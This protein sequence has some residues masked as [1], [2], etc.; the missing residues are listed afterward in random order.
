MALKNPFRRSVKE[1]PAMDDKTVKNEASDQGAA[2]NETQEPATAD[3]PSAGDNSELEILKAELDLLRAEHQAIHD[4][5]V[6]LFAEFDNFRKRTA[7]ERLELL[8]YA[9]ENTLKAVLPV[10][11][12]MDRAIANNAKVDDIDTIR[13]GFNLIHQK[14]V[15]ALG[16]Q[17]LKA[18]PDAKGELFD[19][20]RHEAI[21]KA[22]A[23]NPE[24][25][26]K[27]I[28][29]VENGYTLH[30]KV[31]RYAKVVVGE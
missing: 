30:D 6:R 1:N 28:D 7:K 5:H 24:L 17:G 14:M 9:G 12:D 25:K 27:V 22:P 16:S 20:D 21:T 10:L 31:I 15:H 23:P 3:T 19:T 4:K 26:G 8:Q 13:E 18:M 29:V 11:D 2:L